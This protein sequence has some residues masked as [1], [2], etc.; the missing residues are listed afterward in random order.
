MGGSDAGMANPPHNFR[1][2]ALVDATQGRSLM[3]KEF[4]LNDQEADMRRHFRRN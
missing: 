4:T 1:N 3:L 2:A